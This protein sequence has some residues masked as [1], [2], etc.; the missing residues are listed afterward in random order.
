[1]N[2]RLILHPGGPVPAEDEAVERDEGVGI[3]LD[4]DMASLWKGSSEVWK[5]TS[6]HIVS[7]RLKFSDR[8][9]P[10]VPPVFLYIRCVSAPTHRASQEDK[11]RF[12]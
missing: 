2:D 9:H 6:S 1:M 7:A 11:D 10:A 12:V 4:P 3:V 5:P 8:R